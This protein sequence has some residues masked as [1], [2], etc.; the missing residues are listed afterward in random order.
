MRR[1]YS[2]LPREHLIAETRRLLEEA[3]R[4]HLVA[5]V[6]VGSFLSGGVDSAAVTALMARE[7]A[8]RVKTFSIGFTQAGEA[9]D[10]SDYAA[11][12]SSTLGTEHVTCR[13][14]PEDVACSWDSMVD[15]LDQP[16]ADGVNTWLVSLAAAAEVKAAISGLGG[17]ELFAG[18]PYFANF[19]AAYGKSSG[20]LEAL[21]KWIH[22]IRPN[23][24]TTGRAAVATSLRERT[25]L[26]RRYRS[27]S[28]LGRLLAK[29]W[30]P[31]LAHLDGIPHLP[32]NPESLSPVTILSHAEIN[33][34]L[35]S[36]LLR[37]SDT[38]SMAHSLELRP[39]L[40]DHR[41]VEHALALPDAVKC[42]GGQFKIALVEAVKDLIPAGCWQRPKT[43]FGL[44]FAHWMNTSLN[45]RLQHTLNGRASRIL[46]NDY[47]RKRLL[48]QA[49]EKR[50][51]WNCW[52]IFALLGWLEF[53]QCDI[54]SEVDK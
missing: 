31:V 54:S 30:R 42:S 39:V 11:E 41:L 46:L 3:T 51:D 6:P 44:P 14:S 21:A 4:Y 18:Y 34:Y 7:S 8:A 33:G 1:E 52:S 20:P 16:S 37:D 45:N 15:A 23:R 49:R 38:M 53:T 48:A 22:S 5:D 35:L 29:D 32:E 2:V 10:E 50:A 12:V 40:L 28:Q 36:T 24:F 13:L 17:D 9:V 43:G 27:L 25:V 47:H 26:A 19:C